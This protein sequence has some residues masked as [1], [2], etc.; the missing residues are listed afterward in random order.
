MDEPVNVSSELRVLMAMARAKPDAAT[1]RVARDL[2]GDGIDWDRLLALGRRNNIQALLWRSLSLHLP[3]LLPD[4]QRERF[5]T[6]AQRA[7]L[8]SMS[9]L[10]SLLMVVERL[11]GP[12]DVRYAVLKGAAVSTR[13]YGDPLLR[14]VSDIDLLV[15]SDRIPDVIRRLIAEG[16]YIASPFWK[17]QRLELFA[18]HVGVIEVDSPDGKR[19]EVHRLIDGSGLVFDPEDLLAGATTIE[20]MGRPIP[21]LGA[22]H[23]FQTIVFHHARH[24]WSCYHWVADLMSML[25]SGLVAGEIERAT[26]HPVLGPTVAASVELAR[27]IERVVMTGATRDTSAWSGFLQGC[28]ASVDR[29]EPPEQPMPVDPESTEPDFPEGW[30]KTRRYRM[31]FAATRLRPT[32]TDIDWVALPDRMAWLYWALRPM[33]IGCKHAQRLLGRS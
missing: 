6:L 2:V 10:G 11:L 15:E 24:R 8:H 20:I 1:V 23:E 19:I 31:A 13:W 30:Q 26:Q 22:A 18:S 3:D 4:A 9:M 28:M 12:M 21:V 16:W 27:D 33:R 7:R 32:L 14:K 17:G 29:T 25:D 5:E